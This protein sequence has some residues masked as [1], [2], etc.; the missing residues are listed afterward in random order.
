MS[1]IPEGCDSLLVWSAALKYVTAS[2][3]IFRAYHTATA[4]AKTV[5]AI[6]T[7]TPEEAKDEDEEGIEMENAEENDLEDERTK[8]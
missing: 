3:N 5:A 4:L 8:M 7:P 6:H 2:K 1:T